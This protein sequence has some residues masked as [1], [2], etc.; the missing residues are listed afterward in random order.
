[1][2]QKQVSGFRFALRLII[3]WLL[4]FQ[5][6]RL[7]FFGVMVLSNPDE[8]FS[9]W[10][11][12]F[13]AGFRLDFSAACY[14]SALPFLGW[15]IAIHFPPATYFL[16]F[17][18]FIELLLLSIII[19]VNTGI[20]RAWGT[21]LNRRAVTFIADPGAIIASLSFI[22]LT[23]GL[24]III[25]LF[26]FLWLSMKKMVLAYFQRNDNKLSETL[27][28]F[29]CLLILPL[30]MRGGF[31]QIPVNESAAS[32]SN[33]S[34]LNSAAMNPAWYL[35]N[36]LVKTGIHQEN[37]FQ[38][39]PPETCNQ[40]VRE[41]LNIPPDTLKIFSEDRPNIV[42]IALESWTADI[43]G[44]LGGD[45]SVT[46]FFNQL[47]KE[48]ILFTGIYSSGRRTDQMLPSVFSGFPSQPDFSIIRYPSKTERLPMLIKDLRAAGYSSSFYYGGE[49]GFANMKSYLLQGGMDEMITLDDFRSLKDLNKWGA[50]DQY[51]LKRHAENIMKQ[52]EPSFSFLLTLS[53][54]E[55][56]DVP[57]KKIIQGND[58]SSLFRNAAAY[59]DRQLKEYFESL[60]NYEWYSRTIFMLFADHGHLLPLQR[61]FADPA[62]YHIPVLITGGALRQ[63]F[64]GVQMNQTGA[65]HDLPS[66]LLR[67]LDL[68]NAAY[69]WSNDLLN[70]N[71]VD[72]A[73]MNMDV[74]AGWINK[75]GKLV[76]H[77]PVKSEDKEMTV[78]AL[79]KDD[80]RLLQLK[81]YQQS[82][83]DEFLKY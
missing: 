6:S 17:I 74:A 37:P 83:F 80:E 31:Q 28:A 14:L 5:I 81:A 76:Y 11:Q 50:H 36:N 39:L 10:P 49:P 73:Y 30:G 1:M 21:L 45:S 77:W 29:I 24:I 60:R 35:M 8:S 72:F 16:R 38:T 3:F 54:H 9:G 13:S 66:T 43:I 51:V 64:R 42:F 52:K 56:F 32:F 47:C 78:P 15:L 46:P 53:S 79:E 57:G 55:P 41:L 58:E 7:I 48:G 82:T 69:K 2:R 40:I 62:V 44:P 12:V 23:G 34:R 26:A 20:Y 19:P 67:Q 71:R 25:L 27:I 68:E 22:E 63:E 33:N 70:R 59:T 4:L 61:T 75:K 65:Q 18:L